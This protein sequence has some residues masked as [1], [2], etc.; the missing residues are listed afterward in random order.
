VVCKL[1]ELKLI[2][3]GSMGRHNRR[4]SSSWSSRLIQALADRQDS[5]EEAKGNRYPDERVWYDQFTSTDWLHDII[6]DS[7]RVKRL[8]S[9]KDL[10]GRVLVAL[11]AAQG[12]LLSA[13]VGVI[14]ALIAYTVNVS[15]AIVFDYKDGYCAKA[16]YLDE[17]VS[18][19][20]KARHIPCA[21]S[22]RH[23]VHMVVVMTGLTGQKHSGTIPLVP[24]AQVSASTCS[25][26]LP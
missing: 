16:W 19:V 1:C 6:A 24:L 7:Q 22:H 4:Q 2:I 17:R 18:Q 14:V 5:I 8:R 13:V 21:N 26:A 23:V 3:T 25:Y 12:W 15:E 20:S 9:R 11:D 10:W